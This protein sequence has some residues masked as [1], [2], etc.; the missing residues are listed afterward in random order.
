MFT[1]TSVVTECA[2][3]R[4]N[5]GL[6]TNQSNQP[7]TPSSDQP[8]HEMIVS[9]FFFCA[10]L[11][12]PPEPNETTRYLVGIGGTTRGTLPRSHHSSPR[13]RAHTGTVFLLSPRARAPHTIHNKHR[14]IRLVSCV[15]PTTRQPPPT[16]RND[17][18]DDGDD[19]DET[20]EAVVG[21][22][23]PTNQPTT[24]PTYLPST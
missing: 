21:K 18:D 8:G 15:V 12:H 5:C 9:V 16:P 23:T 14:T 6:Y 3:P 24:K 4:P 1:E 20:A 10:P 13:A 22:G 2:F 19:G 17:E 7:T 11:H